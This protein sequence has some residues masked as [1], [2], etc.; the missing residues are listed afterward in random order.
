M[1]PPKKK[2]HYVPVSYLKAFCADDGMLQVYR[3]DDPERP[4]R[5]RPDDVAFHK[6]Y[7]AQ[8]LPEGGRDADR[9]EDRFSELETKWPVIVERMA[10]ETPLNDSLEE[11]FQ[12]L[13]LQRARVP[14]ARDAA[15]K[16]L[17]AYVMATARQLEA[18]GKAPPPPAGITSALDYAVVSI[19]PHQSIHA[20]AH[21]VRAMGI[22]FDRVGLRVL[23]NKTDVEFLT[24]DNP[25][26]YFDP[27]I[28]DDELLP[29]TIK[30]DGHAVLLMPVSPGLM[31]FGA[32]WDKERFASEGLDSAHLDD[33]AMV[34]L[35]NQQIVRFGYEAIFARG[36]PEEGLV[37]AHAARSPVAKA[38]HFTNN[39]RQAVWFTNVFG[40]REPKPKWKGGS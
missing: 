32:S 40:A 18:D 25:V 30:E 5:K 7:Y 39:G 3:K 11:I 4:F 23:H 37:Q 13:A 28:P 33:V 15:E 14:A 36:T 29:Y 22:I 17:A 31:L 16:M 1:P 34:K 27:A 19:D 35:L 24:S 21:I 12:F 6:Y 8:P 26:A 20:M 38:E 10:D 9:I 2:H